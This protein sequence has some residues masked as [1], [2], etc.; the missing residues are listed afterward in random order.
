[1][2]G[3]VIRKK[4][5]TYSKTPQK[6][7]IRQK[8]SRVHSMEPSTANTK[9]FKVKKLPSKTLANLPEETQ[10]SIRTKVS[11]IQSKTLTYTKIPQKTEKLSKMVRGALFGTFPNQY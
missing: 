4:S 11:V 6:L 9:L 10:F 2:E 7:K 1:M 3:S 5:L 8:R